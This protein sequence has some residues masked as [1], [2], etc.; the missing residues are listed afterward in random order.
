M[1]CKSHVYYYI[2][3]WQAAVKLNDNMLSCLFF[4]LFSA[5]F[6]TSWERT[7]R[8]LTERLSVT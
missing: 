2:S 6:C 1:C 7:C 3:E 4:V 5:M 8:V